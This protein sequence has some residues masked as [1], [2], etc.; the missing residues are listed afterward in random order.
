VCVCVCRTWQREVRY[1]GAD[2]QR[3]SLRHESQRLHHN[4]WHERRLRQTTSDAGEA[5]V[6]TQPE[7]QLRA[8]SRRPW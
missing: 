6:R 5:R 8:G 3:I 1:H 7:G 2:R 4:T